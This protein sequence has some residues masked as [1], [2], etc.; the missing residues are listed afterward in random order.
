[1]HT[2][3]C[4]NLG[5]ALRSISLSNPQLQLILYK[6]VKPLTEYVDIKAFKFMLIQSVQDGVIDE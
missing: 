4:R 2:F 3:L 5:H 6:E 1:M